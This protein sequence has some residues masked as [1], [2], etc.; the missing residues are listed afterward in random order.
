MVAPVDFFRGLQQTVDCEGDL[1]CVQKDFGCQLVERELTES[2]PQTYS[3]Y[4]S[5]GSSLGIDSSGLQLGDQA[6]WAEKKKD[7]MTVITC[8]SLKYF[9]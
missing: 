3:E 2:Q 8:V 1:V 9:I 5:P 4:M 6:G 7:L